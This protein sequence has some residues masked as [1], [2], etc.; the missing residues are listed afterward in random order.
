MEDERSNTSEPSLEDSQPGLNSSYDSIKKGVS[1]YV[2]DSGNINVTNYSAT[3]GL[4]AADFVI[5]KH[6]Q[7]TITA[8]ELL[9]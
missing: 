5:L 6:G 2:S 3:R 7:V 9:T 4:L 1:L 8:P